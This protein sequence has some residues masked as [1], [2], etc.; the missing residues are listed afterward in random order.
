MDISF[1]TSLYR[2][3]RFLPLYTQRLLD[4]IQPLLQAHLTLEVL[5]VANDADDTERALINDLIVQAAC[6]APALTIQAH[7][8]PRENLYASWNRGL[9]LMQGDIF[10]FW[11]VDDF[12]H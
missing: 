5:L 3:A 2:S 7:Y 1:I 4:A 9:R 10:G 8:V 12:R 11:N 6:Y